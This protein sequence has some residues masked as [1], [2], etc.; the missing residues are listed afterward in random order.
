[1]PRTKEA[2]AP[3]PYV[4]LSKYYLDTYRETDDQI[5]VGHFTN[6]ARNGSFLGPPI[7]S[8]CLAAHRCPHPILRLYTV[9]G[10]DTS[11]RR[12]TMDWEGLKQAVLRKQGSVVKL[13]ER[14]PVAEPRISEGTVILNHNMIHCSPQANSM[15]VL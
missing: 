15:P 8:Y 10:E 3:Q 9:N 5:S 6:L 11:T 4:E 7:R 13:Q 1:M 2:S 14:A 12:F